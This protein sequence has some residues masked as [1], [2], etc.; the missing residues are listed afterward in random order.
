MKITRVCCQGCGAD[1]EV[2]EDVR[3]ATCNYCHARLEIVHDTSVTHTRLMEKLERT[4]DRIAGN[5]RVIELQNDL[6]Q[7]DRSWDRVR[8][9]YMVRGKHGH[10]RFPSAGGS[11]FSGIVGGFAGIMLLVFS[12]GNG[13]G[14]FAVFGLV[15]IAV[16]VAAAF[17]GLSKARAYDSAEAAYRAKRDRI[18][19]K[20]GEERRS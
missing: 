5:L 8:E 15:F 20:I 12:T 1:L 10:V 11:I 17:G 4:T 18:L 6:E 9:S 3:F 19:D 16:S 14:M 7:L 13:L 2:D